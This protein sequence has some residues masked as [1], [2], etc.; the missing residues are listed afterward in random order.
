M[1]TLKMPFQIGWDITHNCNLRCKHCFFT[2]EQLS[3]KSSFTKE[4]AVSFVEY[5]AKKKVFHLS[6]AGGEPLLYP[7]LIDVIEN[8]HKKWN[9]CSIV[10]KCNFTY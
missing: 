10:N 2:A 3:D 6:L 7:H 5:L 4:E 1:K 8:S 9:A